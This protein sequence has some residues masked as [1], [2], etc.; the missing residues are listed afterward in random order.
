MAGG[1]GL[2][3]GSLSGGRGCEVPSAAVRLRTPRRCAWRR[4][5]MAVGGRWL[6]VWRVLLPAHQRQVLQP[7]RTCAR[8]ASSTCQVSPRAMGTMGVRPAVPNNNWALVTDAHVMTAIGVWLQRATGCSQPGCGRRRA[9][10]SVDGRASAP[11]GR[12]SQRLW[13]PITR[14]RLPSAMWLH[15]HHNA[16]PRLSDGRLF[17]IVVMLVAGGRDNHTGTN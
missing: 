13:Q 1:R 7:A 11:D 17:A 15:R 4:A 2:A 12:H 9:P 6:R 5:V 16:N 3:G 10:P 14:N 8:D